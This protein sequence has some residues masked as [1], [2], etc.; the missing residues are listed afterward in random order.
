MRSLMREEKNVLCTNRYLAFQTVLKQKTKKH[1][2]LMSYS[3]I[4]FV[5]NIIGVLENF[6]H[7]LLSLI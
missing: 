3:R 7:M 2:Y 4:I 5:V 1:Q 6:I